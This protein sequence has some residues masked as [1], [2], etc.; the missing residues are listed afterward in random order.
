MVHDKSDTRDIAAVFQK[1]EEE[2][3]DHNDRNET[4]YTADTCENSVNDQAVNGGI[5][6]CGGQYIVYRDSQGFDPCLQQSLQPGADHIEGQI[7]DGRH[8]QDEYWDCCVPACQDPINFAASNMLTALPGTVD[9]LPADL[10]D[11]GVAHVSDCSTLVHSAL[12]FH[13]DNDMIE[14]L[15]LILIEAEFIKQEAIAFDDLGGGKS[16]R[17]VCALCMVFDQVGDSMETTMYGTA[18][19]VFITEILPQGTFLIVGDMDGV[20]HQF[21][22]AFSACSGDRDDR[23]SQQRLEFIDVNGSSV[24]ADFIHHI[25]GH[26]H[27]YVH[28]KQL[29][30]QIHV[31]LNIGRIDDIDDG[32]GL[33]LQHIIAGDEL[34]TAVG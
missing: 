30:G 12:I 26:D 22:N 5:D 28:F 7:E 18:V 21:L 13:L 3:H 25:E 2:E 9:S 17:Q 16:N 27:G 10:E 31:A 4:Q 32:P 6:I 20:I 33:F 15:L 14:Q 24:A 19:I 23:N 1:R 8:D 11:K 29:D 34:F